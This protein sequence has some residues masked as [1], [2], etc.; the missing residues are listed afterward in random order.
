M[1]SSAKRAIL[2]ALALLAATGAFAKVRE[3]F[4]KVVPFNPGGSFTIET[5]N[6]SIEIGTWNEPNVQILAEK[7]ASSEEGLENLE[8]V[9]EGSGDRVS[10]ET[11]HHRKQTHWGEGGQ[12]S[13]RIL[14]PAEAHVSAQTANGAVEI[15]GIHGR[16]EAKSVNGSLKVENVTGEI[17]AETTNGSIRASYEKALDGRHRFSTTN[18]AVRIYLPSD[19][20]GELDAETV[21]GSIDVDF[22]VTVTRTSR[23]HLR[24]SFGSGTSSFEVSTVNGSVKVLAN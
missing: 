2:T 3:T 5:R 24:G 22:P 23:R 20:G 6:G 14:L 16:V 12:V 21:N 13:Y 17:Q 11:I 18:G 19:A 9:V 15:Q 1:P 8:I 4:E 7:T 10:V